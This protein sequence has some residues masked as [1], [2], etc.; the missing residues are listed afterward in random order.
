MEVGPRS[1]RGLWGEVLKG[2]QEVQPHSEGLADGPEQSELVRLH[3]GEGTVAAVSGEQGP[4]TR[5]EGRVELLE[6]TP[7]FLFTTAPTW[8]SCK[9]SPRLLGS[10]AH[11]ACPAASLPPLISLPS[12]CASSRISLHIGDQG[13]VWVSLGVVLEVGHPLIPDPLPTQPHSDS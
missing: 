12:S 6:E 10:P 9:S 4:G 11:P 1:W 3:P 7:S 13:R 8:L 5:D 2:S